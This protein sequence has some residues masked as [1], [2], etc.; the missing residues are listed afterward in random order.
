MCVTYRDKR[1]REAET[2]GYDAFGQTQCG[3]VQQRTSVS[4]APSHCIQV[5]ISHGQYNVQ[6]ATAAAVDVGDEI[7]SAHIV[8]AANLV[9]HG[10]C[11]CRCVQSMKAST[12]CRWSSCLSALAN[13]PAQRQHG[14]SLQGGCCWSW[15]S[16]M[17]RLALI[18]GQQ[19]DGS[20]CGCWCL[21]KSLAVLVLTLSDCLGCL[22]HLS[23]AVA[24]VS[25]L[26]ARS[27][28]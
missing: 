6:I 1:A 19:E 27:L 8:A 11:C 4:S 3:G 10:C 15:C 7:I 20:H 26:E 12:C 23:L 2:V 13:C 21:L 14:R 24:S 22:L 5:S 18:D 16:K 25:H 28:Q 9:C 17:V